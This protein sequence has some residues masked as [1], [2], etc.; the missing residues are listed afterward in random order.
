MVGPK[1]RSTV[2]SVTVVA[3]VPANLSRNAQCGTRAPVRKNRARHTAYTSDAAPKSKFESTVKY[4][5]LYNPI[6]VSAMSL[7]ENINMHQATGTM[8]A[9]NMLSARAPQV[10]FKS[11]PPFMY[12]AS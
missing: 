2:I 11:A 1:N 10:R 7:R 9:M 12:H 8:M 4:F 5:K 3:T 6:A